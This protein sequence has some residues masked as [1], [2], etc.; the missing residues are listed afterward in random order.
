MV[1]VRG[2]GYVEIHCHGGTAMVDS[3]LVDIE[4]AGA[5]RVD[6]REFLARRGASIFRIEATEA[7]AQA[8]TERTARILMD[9]YEGALEREWSR[10]SAAPEPARAREILQW[11]PIGLHLV[12]PWRI[13]FVGRP[14]I[15]KSSLLN[16]LLG[17]D[18]AIVANEAGT[19]RDL[20][21]ARTAFDGWPVELIDGSGIRANAGGLEA[22]GM[23]RVRAERPKVDLCVQLLDIA[24][25]PNADDDWIAQSMNPD[26]KIGTRSDLPFAWNCRETV[27]LLCSARIGDGLDRVIELLVHRLVPVPPPPGTAVPFTAR[28]VERFQELAGLP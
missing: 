6:W 20:L 9:Q 19:T 26:Y 28:Q 22:L 3:L 15:G 25:P 21:T 16:R 2:S 27:D 13:L 4:A 8:P 14:N 17:Y 23:E 24:T 5:E 1:W 18:R 10:L 11:A 12:T 7:L